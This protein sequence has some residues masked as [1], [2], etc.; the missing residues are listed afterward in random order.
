MTMQLEMWLKRATRHLSWDAAAQVRSE[1]GEHYDAA[2]ESAM[3][4]GAGL[5]EADR[6]AIAALGDA[7]TANRQYRKVLLTSREARLL[8]EGNWE[9]RAVCSRRW[10][11]PVSAWLA[12]IAFYLAGSI[13]MA[14]VLVVGGTAIGVIFF[15]TFLPVYTPARGRVFRGVKRVML[16]VIL[17]LAFSP[18]TLRWSGLLFSC[19]WPVAWIEW[20]RASIRR[21][22]PVEKWPKQ[23]YL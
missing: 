21:K 4:G 22:L 17:L 19:V 10:L 1:I 14:R 23:L 12:A 9:A 13:V 8:R 20:T 7:Q 16:A 5:D 11:L 2:L 15:A 3:A 6:V 18:L